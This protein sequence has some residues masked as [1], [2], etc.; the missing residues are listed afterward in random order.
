[1]GETIQAYDYDLPPE[2]IAQQPSPARDH[3][4]LM[5]LKRATREIAHHRFYELPDLLNPG[6]LII[7]N[8]TRV[9]PARLKGKK[10]TGGKIELLL[11]EKKEPRSYTWRCMAKR[12]TRLKPG[13]RLFFRKGVEGELLRIEGGG[14]VEVTFSAPLTE[15]LLRQIGE[16]P[17]PPYISRPDGPSGKDTLRYQ[18]IFARKAGA[19]AAP[20]AGLHFSPQLMDDLREKGIAM[21]SLTLHVGPGTFLPIRESEITAHRMH[22]EYYEISEECAAHIHRAKREGRRVIAVGTT[23]VR[24]LESAAKAGQVRAGARRTSLFIHPP[25]VFQI[26]DGMI[27][28]FHLPRSTLLLLVCSFATREF[29]LQAYELAK[30]T[31]YRFYSYGDAMMIL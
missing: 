5:V 21:A 31:G 12:V 22:E 16:I 26:V 15:G 25:Y 20:T 1:M 17:L 28:N 6:D 9:I 11:V 3:D 14:I 10:A 2:L 13:A 8:D 18:T 29:I 23:V 7:I 27:T 24:S 4:R 30:R 19:V